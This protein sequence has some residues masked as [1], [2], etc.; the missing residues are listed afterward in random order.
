MAELPNGEELQGPGGPQLAGKAPSLGRPPVMAPP[1]PADRPPLLEQP[2]STG[3]PKV[4]QYGYKPIVP[5]KQFLPATKTG[6]VGIGK[7]KSHTGA[8]PSPLKLWWYVPENNEWADIIIPDEKIRSWIKSAAEYQDV[9]LEIMAV[10]LQQENGANATGAQ[11]FIQ[12][13]ERTVTTGLQVADEWLFDLVPDRAF[14]VAVADGSSGIANLQRPTL[15]DAASYSEKSLKRPPLPDDVRYRIFG[16]D[17]DTRISGDDVKADLYYQAAHIRQLID[18]ITGVPGYV[19]N[20]TLDQVRSVIRSYNGSGKK[21]NKYADD[22]MKK[23]L[24][25]A[26]GR[27]PLYFYQP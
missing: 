16:W 3:E 10:I 11:K 14:G 24:D 6:I 7:I 8:I 1:A 12:F 23:L 5:E 17:Q 25:A 26:D 22:G 20:L 15:R 18:R 9:P 4:K 27:S 21:A 2:I 13:G 19:G